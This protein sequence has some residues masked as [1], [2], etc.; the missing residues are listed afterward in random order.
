MTVTDDAAKQ[1]L[2]RLR[3]D[4][5]RVLTKTWSVRLIVIAAVLSGLEVALSVATAFAIKPPMP[6]GIFAALSGLVTVAAFAARFFAQ[7]KD[8]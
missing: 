7:Q 6:A 4:W 3:E 5:H 2:L 8:A 1:G